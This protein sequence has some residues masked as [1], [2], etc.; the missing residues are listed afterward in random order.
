MR[1]GNCNLPGSSRRGDGRSCNTD[2]VSSH[3]R[4]NLNLRDR[5]LLLQLASNLY[6]AAVI[7]SCCSLDYIPETVFDAV[8]NQAS[9]TSAVDES[10]LVLGPWMTQLLAPATSSQPSSVSGSKGRPDASPMTGAY[11]SLASTILSWLSATLA[12]SHPYLKVYTTTSL[13]PDLIHC[14]SYLL[15]EANSE[16]VNS[17]AAW[18]GFSSSLSSFV[19]FFGLPEPFFL[20]GIDSLGP[21]L[22]LA[23]NLPVLLFPTFNL[24][25]ISA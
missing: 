1:N 4:E 5:S 10:E 12:S 14:L 21:C 2:L 3:P 23:I 24:F 6:Q 9:E 13:S 7:S 19:I 15:R 22:C 17:V 16:A 20:L 25:A 8:E 18:P 11:L